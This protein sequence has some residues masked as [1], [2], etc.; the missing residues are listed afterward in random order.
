MIFSVIIVTT[1][2]ITLLNKKI[3]QTLKLR[4]IGNSI[5]VTFPKELLE[6]LKLSEGDTLFVTETEQGI[7]LSPYDPE[8]EQAIAIYQEGN[9]K[10]RNALRKLAQ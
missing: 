6:K 7:E 8:F 3:M 2:V 10:F 9:Q 5:G 4:K 1:N